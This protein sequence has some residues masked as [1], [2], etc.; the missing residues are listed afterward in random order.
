MGLYNIMTRSFHVKYYPLLTREASHSRH[1]SAH[2]KLNLLCKRMD[3]RKKPE[4]NLLVTDSYRHLFRA[5]E[6]IRSNCC[7]IR[8][9]P[10]MQT[11]RWNVETL[12]RI[13]NSPGPCIHF[14]IVKKFHFLR[15]NTS[16]QQT[17]HLFNSE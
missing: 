4:K 13:C 11:L 16:K 12:R 17:L 15:N 1:P 10:A 9:V 6:C 7:N 8:T 5:L 2:P 3:L 14:I